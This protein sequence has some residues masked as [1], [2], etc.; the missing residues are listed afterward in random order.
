MKIIG[1]IMVAE[2]RGHKALALGIITLFA[3]QGMTQTLWLYKTTPFIAICLQALLLLLVVLVLSKSLWHDAPLRKE[4]YL[5]TRP[6]NLPKLYLGKYA[7]FLLMIAAPSAL[8]EFLRVR[9]FSFDL[10]IQAAAALQMFLLYAFAIAAFIPVIWWMHSKKSIVMIWVTIVGAG[11]ASNYYF[12]K[13]PQ[14]YI[15]EWSA[16]VPYSH[17]MIMLM[18]AIFAVMANLRLLRLKKCHAMISCALMAVGVFVSMQLAI[19]VSARKR[20]E[21]PVRKCHIANFYSYPIQRGNVRA[22]Q[23]K[24]P[25]DD[26]DLDTESYWSFR[27][28]KLNDQDYTPWYGNIS[29]IGSHK[30][31]IFR[32]LKERYPHAKDYEWRDDLNRAASVSVPLELS[33][34]MLYSKKILLSHKKYRWKII[35]DLPLHVGAKANNQKFS[36]HIN[37][38]TPKNIHPMNRS[39]SSSHQRIVTVTQCNPFGEVNPRIDI[40]QLHK[41]MIIESVSGEVFPNHSYTSFNRQ[42]LHYNYEVNTYQKRSQF[43]L[44]NHTYT[45]HARVII[46]IPEITEEKLYSWEHH[47]PP[48]KL[49]D[50]PKEELIENKLLGYKSA[51]SWFQENPSPSDQDSQ[52]V[53]QIWVD[54][55][56]DFAKKNP[57]SLNRLD[58]SDPIMKAYKTHVDLFAKAHHEGRLPSC[59]QDYDFVKFYS[60]DLVKKHPNLAHSRYVILHF[61]DK[62]WSSYLVETARDM[63]RRGK[64][65]YYEDIILAEPE[66]MNLTLD[67]WVDFYRLRCNAEAYKALKG[68]IISVQVINEITDQHLAANQN[69]ELGLVRGH[70][71]APYWLKRDALNSQH[72]CFSMPIYVGIYFELSSPL[73][74]YTDNHRLL[75][76]PLIEWIHKF[77]PDAYVYDSAKQKYILKPTP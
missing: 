61:R 54:E 77:D 27:K 16:G 50:L 64:G 59:L 36:C 9:Y 29:V 39:A 43:E 69:V 6:T 76:E 42:N 3:L 46:M 52:T 17:Y 57:Q 72:A 32:T 75:K 34:E 31:E 53:C 62:G 21:E 60:R 40:R 7:A 4:R 2:L 48:S 33:E 65:I 58:N 20:P 11:V 68:R 71:Q 1:A 26:F 12:W 28:V 15:N 41:M 14:S 10:N 23:A 66:L 63:L 25:H 18:L 45:E 67:E 56:I 49:P 13:Q 51:S 22:F 55:F 38:A 47:A 24:V 5:A 74:K 73:P 35:M 8:V 70:A 44:E 30:D 37:S 19:N